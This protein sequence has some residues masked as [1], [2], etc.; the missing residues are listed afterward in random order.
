MTARPFRFHHRWELPAS[1]HGVFAALAD[2][3][4]YQRW[5]PQVRSGQRIDERSGRV[6]I[7]SAV[8]IS[9]HLVL[10]REI[11]DAEGGRL[12]VRLAGDR[13]FNFERGGALK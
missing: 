4:G 7:R 2:V 1:P 10:T 9:L 3:D 5:W 11:E 6:V 13:L 12:R 8:P